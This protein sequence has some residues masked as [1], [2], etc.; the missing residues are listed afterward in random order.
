MIGIYPIVEGHGEVR[1]VPELI[2]RVLWEVFE[3]YEFEVISAHRLK[4]GQMI[5]NESQELLRA[6]QLGVSKIRQSYDGGLV[7]VI[8]DADDDCPAEIGPELHGRIAREDVSTSVVVAQ[9][10]Y[11][12]WLLASA[13]SL[14]DHRRVRDDAATPDNPEQIRDAK[15][16]LERNVLAA[17]EHYSPTIDQQA[18]TAIFDIVQ[19]RTAASFDKL[20]RD[21]GAIVETVRQA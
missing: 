19:A 20:C 12:A 4:R 11:E 10:E 1:S 17:G 21:I 8:L 13:D 2:R 16:H 9:R 14:A 5:A 7:I 18:L 15:G 3:F 6:V